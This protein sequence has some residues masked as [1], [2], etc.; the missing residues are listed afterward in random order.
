M[1][2]LHTIAELIYLAGWGVISGAVLIGWL[3]WRLP[4]AVVVAVYWAWTIA[5]YIVTGRLHKD[6]K[7]PWE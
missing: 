7:E 5:R 1:R 4:Q 6:D 2:L 3:L